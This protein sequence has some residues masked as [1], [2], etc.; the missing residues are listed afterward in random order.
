MK[1]E[2]DGRRKLFGEK[3]QSALGF[4]FLAWLG[5]GQSICVLHVPFRRIAQINFMS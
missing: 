4:L 2:G 3:E 5:V 1:E